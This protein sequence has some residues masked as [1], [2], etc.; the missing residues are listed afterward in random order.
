ME[1]ILSF[2]LSFVIFKFL[3]VA[4]YKIANFFKKLFKRS[5]G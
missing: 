4:W 2:I 3:N 1:F 5:D